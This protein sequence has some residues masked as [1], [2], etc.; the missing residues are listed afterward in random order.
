MVEMHAVTA[1]V[2]W[3]TILANSSGLTFFGFI[4]LLLIYILKDKVY[5]CRI[6]IF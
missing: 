5:P 4:S 1:N 2:A 3:Q 6:L